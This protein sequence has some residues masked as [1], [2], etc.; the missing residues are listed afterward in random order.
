MT[1]VLAMMA[2][3]MGQDMSF[4]RGT[5]VTEAAHLFSVQS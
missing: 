5:Q 4:D 2:L 3:A 1:L